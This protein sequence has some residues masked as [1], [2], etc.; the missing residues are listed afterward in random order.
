MPLLLDQLRTLWIYFSM[1]EEWGRGE[2]IMQYVR[3]TARN[4]LYNRTS[5]PRMLIWQRVLLNSTV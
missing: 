4:E 5:N 2:A 3:F 1:V